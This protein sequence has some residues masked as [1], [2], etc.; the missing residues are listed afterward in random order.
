[1]VPTLR[2]TLAAAVLT[3]GLSACASLDITPVNEPTAMPVLTPTNTV[4][5][6]DTLRPTIVGLAFSGG[7]MRASAFSY[8][9]LRGLERVPVEGG[10]SMLDQVRFVSGVSGGSVTAAWFGLRGRAGLGDF[11]QRFLYRDAEESLRRSFYSVTNITRALDSGVNDRNGFPAWL[12]KNLFG[13]ATFR[14]LNRPGRPVVWINASDITSKTPFIFEPVTFGSICS[15][16]ST[17]PI[18]EAVAASAAVPIVFAPVVIKSYADKCGF[19]LPDHLEEM[20]RRRDS[21]PIVRNYISALRKYR[22]IGQVAFVKLLDGGLTDNWG[23]A[24]FNVA[25]ASATEPYKPLNRDDAV[26]VERFI[27]VVVDSGRTL[28]SDYA[29]TLEGPSGSALLEAVTDTAIDS[30]VRNSFEVLRLQMQAWESR[31][32]TWRCALNPDEV[33]R[34]RGSTEGWDCRKVS[35][36]VERIAFEDLDAGTAQTLG[37]IPTR[38]VLD[39]A[40]VKASIEGGANAAI[41]VLGAAES[42]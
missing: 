31:L 10:G 26:V 4:G 28:P 38:F 41:R 25:L 14:D 17:Y 40:E 9:V 13:N 5:G 39:P 24:G 30:A 37:R 3:G 42:H 19:K 7:G 27:F 11:E 36:R 32:K 16:L 34:I 8:G 22:D 18:A 6:D 35:V 23:L 20:A 1:M 2:A 21:S 29:K 15:D 12:K 33:A